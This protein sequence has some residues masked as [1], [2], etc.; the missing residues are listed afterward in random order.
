LK[1]AEDLGVECHW[2]C[3]DVRVESGAIHVDQKAFRF[4]FTVDAA[5][6][7]KIARADLWQS[8]AGIWVESSSPIFETANATLMDLDVPVCE[9]PVRFMY[10]LPTSPTT[11]LVEHTVFHTAPMPAQWH[12]EACDRWITHQGLGPLKVLN[13]EYGAIPM[14][15]QH[16]AS[17]KG[18]VRIGTT[19]GSLRA[20]TGYGFQAIMRDTELL[21]QRIIDAV[22]SEKKSISPLPPSIPW[23]MGYGDRLFVRAL[24][25]EGV[26][27]QRLM[28]SLLRAAPERELIGFLAGRANFFEALQVMKCVPKYPM[29]KSLLY[30][31]ASSLR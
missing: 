6:D 29:V 4:D 13:S 18:I 5:H 14:G 15:L 26:R 11:A 1:V 12:L 10:I 21:A 22:S 20:S 9:A 27:G 16:S 31:C 25:R 8:F 24:A 19:G 28:E 7:S 23:W 17:P 30:D 2:E 3:R